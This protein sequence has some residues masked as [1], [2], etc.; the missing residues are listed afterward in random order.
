MEDNTN[1]HKS[2]E[3]ECFLNKR[4]VKKGKGLIIKYLIRW[5]RYGP[6][7]NKWY[8]IKD[9]NNTDDLV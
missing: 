5:T 6:K 4:A 9:L 8:N 1:Y 3:I 2:F 7:W